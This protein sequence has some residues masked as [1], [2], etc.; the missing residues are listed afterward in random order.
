MGSTRP[1]AAVV[2]RLGSVVPGV[3]AL[4][5]T[6]RLGLPVSTP[7]GALS[8]KPSA[9]SYADVASF[10]AGLCGAFPVGC[11]GSRSSPYVLPFSISDHVMANLDSDT[12]D[13]ISKNVEEFSSKAAIFRFRGC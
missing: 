4:G 5:R 7:G 1:T 10:E 11:G 6:A 12:V 3:L 2:A 13:D 9:I 8:I